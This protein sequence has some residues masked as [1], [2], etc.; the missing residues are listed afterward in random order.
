MKTLAK[1]EKYG[2]VRFYINNVPTAYESKCFID[3]KNGKAKLVFVAQRDTIM[4]NLGWEA[5]E[6][7]LGKKLT[8]TFACSGN[9]E[10]DEDL[11]NELLEEFLNND[12]TEKADDD[13]E[14]E[15]KINDVVSHREFGK[16]TVTN[17]EKENEITV[18]FEN[19]TK[20][21]L[22]NFLTNSNGET[23]R[24]KKTDDTIVLNNP[25]NFIDFLDDRDYCDTKSLNTIKVFWDIYE[26][27]YKQFCEENEVEHENLGNF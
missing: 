5:I 8:N 27:E 16:G 23:F 1:W 2:K 12:T 22:K 14:N 10:I 6:N 21:I 7:A 9:N 18:K 20:T 24:V 26:D 25:Y 11:F 13:F 15:L 17:I 3:L 4:E 19:E